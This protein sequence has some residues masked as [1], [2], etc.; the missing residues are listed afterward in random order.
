MLNMESF[1]SAG[2]TQRKDSSQIFNKIFD[3]V[4]APQAKIN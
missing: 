1:E 2:K 3:A 4:K